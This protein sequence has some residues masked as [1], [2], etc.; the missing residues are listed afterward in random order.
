MRCARLWCLAVA[1]AGVAGATIAQVRPASPAQAPAIVTSTAPQD[2]ALTVYRAPDG[3]G[4][5][6][7]RYLGGFALITETRRVTLP[8][9]PAVLRFEGVAE[10][11][12]PVSA[13]VEGLPGGVVEKNRD[14]RLLSPA[15]LVD[16]TLGKE[17]TLTRTDK[18]TGRAVSEPATIVA[19]PE[20]GVVL[21]T[22]D[23]IETLRCSGLPERLSFDRVPPGLSSKPVLS[24]STVSPTARTA[25]IRLSYLASGFDWRASYVATVAQDGASLDL[26]AW[27]TLANSNGQT[28]PR[29]RISAVAG[30]LNRI[31]TRDLSTAVR[32]L[33]LRCYPLGTTTSDLRLE[34]HE[35]V[36][37][38][39]RAFAVPQMALAAPAPPPPPP[40]PP[41]E[42]LGDLK[43]Y[44]APER[45]TVSARGQKQIALLARQQVSFQRRYRASVFPAQTLDAAPTTIVLAMRNN[46]ESGLG[47]PLPAGS[48]AAYGRRVDGE[49]LLLGLG[50]MSDRAEG[51]AFHLSTGTSHQVTIEQRVLASGE[52]R[53][54]ATN[55][56]AWP[57]TLDISIGSVRQEIKADPALPRVNGIATWT[58]TVPPGARADLTYR[59]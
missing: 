49:R 4:A 40:P 39:S 37:T 7:L 38:A 23:G 26:F 51:E 36:V 1:A 3:K 20:P 8:R 10:G 46:I 52:M 59:Y 58:V 44:R 9:G 42:D 55:A 33:S 5:I 31:V 56:T 28:F 50:N 57:A 41:P 34:K 22:A 30:R 47:L 27:L 35:I 11:I 15:A 18:G 12:I 32:A 54:S 53:L 24:I 17:V 16:G 21:R 45:A 2:L 6:N 19:G 43:L 14:A 29:A 48:T 13:V 25:T